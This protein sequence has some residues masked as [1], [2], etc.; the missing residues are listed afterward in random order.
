MKIKKRK[1]VIVVLSIVILILAIAFFISPYSTA[2]LKSKSHFFN[3]PDNDIV[4]FEPGAEEYADSIANYIATAIERVEKV[5]GLPFEEAFKIYVCSTQKSFNEFAVNTSAYPIRGTALL[6]NVF[7]APSAFDFM[8]IDTHKETLK[9]ELSHLHFQQ[10]LGFIERRELPVWFSEGF[11][12]YVAGS[13]GEGIE[14]SDAINFILSGKHFIPEKE[15]SLFGS[16]GSALNGLSGPMFHQQVKMFVAYII[17]S[18][19][20]KFKSFIMKIREGGSFSETFNTI[21]G[22]K[23]KD[24]WANFLLGLKKRGSN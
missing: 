11:A 20:L 17:N 21:M 19:S 15:G 13:G 4:L 5:H 18:D 7:I 22:Y 1:T 16:V 9:H 12:D 2:L 14:E 8:G 23:I 24:K 10:R 6:G 3:H